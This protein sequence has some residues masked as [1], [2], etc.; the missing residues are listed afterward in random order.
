MHFN[1]V[2]PFHFK[3]ALY[4]ILRKDNDS[5]G[6]PKAT[7]NELTSK[8][9]QEE[10][11]HFLLSSQRFGRQ[12]SY[13][14][15]STRFFMKCLF[16]W[17][18]HHQEK[19]TALSECLRECRSVVLA[20]EQGAGLIS[21]GFLIT[22]LVEDENGRWTLWFAPSSSSGPPWEPLLRI[23]IFSGKINVIWSNILQVYVFMQRR[24]FDHT[25]TNSSKRTHSCPLPL[26]SLHRPV[27]ENLKQLAVHLGPI[28]F[29]GERKQPSPAM[30]DGAS[31]LYYHQRYPARQPTRWLN[32]V[33]TQ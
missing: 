28:S 30:A 25:H 4:C 1:F 21:G 13:I 18:A 10:Y 3:F 27:S 31:V 23:E 19:A 22:P 17:V 2:A 9:Q 11:G 6:C 8:G 12:I 14:S 5:V 29:P 33:R 7:Q 20:G 15:P 26:W 16:T 32:M 24:S